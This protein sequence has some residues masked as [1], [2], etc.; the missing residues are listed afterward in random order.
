[1]QTI[2]ILSA[3][4]TDT[5]YAL[6]DKIFDLRPELAV[7]VDEAPVPEDA[8]ESIYQIFTYEAVRRLVARGVSA[9][10]FAEPRVHVFIRQIAAEIQIPLVDPCDAD[11]RPL[12]REAYARAIVSCDGK[13]RPKPFRIGIAGGLGPMAS[14]D[15]Y[16]KL[17]VLTKASCDQEHFKLIIDQNPQTPDRTK[18]LTEG[19]ENPTLALYATAK[20]LEAA[21]CDAIAYACNTAHAFLPEIF[22]RISVPLVDM[23]K[24][25]LEEI[26]GHFGKKTPAGL[27]ATT[28]TVRTRLYTDKALELGMR[29][30]IPDDAN[31]ELVMRS[32]YGPEG[33]KAGFTEGQCRKDLSQAA[34][35]LGKTYGVKV[36]ILGCTELPLI[37][38]EGP[39]HI[40][41]HDFYCVDP[42]AAV[43]RAL[44]ALARKARAEGR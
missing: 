28:G 42:T 14:V 32:I 36:L 1:M 12:D 22:K 37:F 23:Q 16:H 9:V 5:A 30:F 17:T 6:K 20:R 34:L 40:D 19:G 41:G 35:Y 43:A 13:P 31:Q 18:Y 21:G 10:A 11:G 7:F 3:G 33:V 39:L 25:S 8:S 15:M 38:K 26:A 24:T 2:G 4:K 29:L 44:I 27:L